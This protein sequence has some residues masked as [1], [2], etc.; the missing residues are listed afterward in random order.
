MALEIWKCTKCEGEDSPC[1]VIGAYSE[2]PKVCVHPSHG[3]AK[4]RPCEI[5]EIVEWLPTSHN[6]AMDAISAYLKEY[7]TKIF[8]DPLASGYEQ[9]AIIARKYVNI[10]ERIQHQ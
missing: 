5:S 6:I 7:K 2:D 9:A 3:D 10:F 1:F 4:W 8:D